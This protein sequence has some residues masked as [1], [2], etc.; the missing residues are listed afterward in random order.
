MGDKRNW[1]YERPEMAGCITSPDGNITWLVHEE[2]SVTGNEWDEKGNFIVHACNAHPKLIE[3]LKEAVRL[4]RKYSLDLD[5]Y[6][7]MM[8]QDEATAGEL[9]EDINLAVKLKAWDILLKD[10]KQ[11]ESETPEQII[12]CKG[13]GSDDVEIKVW[14]NQKTGETSDCGDEDDDTWC[15]KCEEHAGITFADAKQK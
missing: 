1:K 14:Q 13:C 7:M 12:V 10:N 9:Q 6:D 3:A 11:A 5:G 4:I 2:I 15:N 8:G